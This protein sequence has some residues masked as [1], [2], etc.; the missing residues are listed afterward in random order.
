MDMICKVCFGNMV[1]KEEYPESQ[2]YHIK[3]VNF[4]HSSFRI[5]IKDNSIYTSVLYVDNDRFSYSRGLLSIMIER[6]DYYYSFEIA[7]LD[8]TDKDIINKLR[9]IKKMKAFL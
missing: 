7:G 2:F 8:F 5:F 4:Q 3:C 1:K 9:R 6:G